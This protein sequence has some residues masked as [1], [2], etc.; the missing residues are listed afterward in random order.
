MPS[1]PFI[2]EDDVSINFIV[3]NWTSLI[4]KGCFNRIEYECN[5][6]NN[7]VSKNYYTEKTSFKFDGLPPETQYII[8]ITALAKNRSIRSEPA[9]MNVTTLSSNKKEENGKPGL[10]ISVRMLRPNFW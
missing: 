6:K 10:H 4:I 5:I 3:C 9:V 8:S 2:L 1:S 7:I